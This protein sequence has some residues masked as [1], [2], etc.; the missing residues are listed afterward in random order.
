LLKKTCGAWGIFGPFVRIGS[1]GELQ[2]VGIMH[3]F[4]CEPPLSQ[5]LDDPLTQ[6]LMDSDGVDPRA[7]RELLSDAQQRIA[8]AAP[9]RRSPR[10]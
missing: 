7:L 10:R 8:G 6:A 3:D 2:G 4:H 5:M 1:Y 9:E